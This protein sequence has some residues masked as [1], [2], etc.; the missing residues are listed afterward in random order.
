MVCNTGLPSVTVSPSI[1]NV[2]VTLTTILTATVTG[3]GPFTY[4]WQR[5]EEILTDETKSSYIIN[6]ASHEDQNYY[7]C[8][9]TNKVGDSAIS[10]RVWLQITSMYLLYYIR[11]GTNVYLYFQEIFHTL[12][13]I[14]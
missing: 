2:E 7:S 11:V 3:V 8:L 1:Q 14:L 13:N 9:V 4:Q 10:N 5:G 6:N 12:S